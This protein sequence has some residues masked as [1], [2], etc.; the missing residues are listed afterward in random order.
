M[1]VTGCH[2]PPFFFQETKI[3]LSIE[4]AFDF[5]N[6]VVLITGAATGIGFSTAQQFAERGAT[7]V[8]VDRDEKIH[9]VT[10]ALGTRHLSLVADVSNEET[11]VSSVT[12][13][14]EK[15]GRIDVLVNNAGIGPLS[16]SEETTSALWDATMAVNLKGSFL[17]AREVGKH[18]ILRKRGRIINMASQAALVA[19]DGHLAYCASKAG[20]L[21]MTRVMAQEWGPL[22]ITVNAISPTVVDTE[23]GARGSWAGEIGAAFKKKIP[24]GRFALPVEIAMS[25]LYLASGAAAMVNGANIVVDGGYTAG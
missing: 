13:A 21:G 8:L 14:I 25:A 20:V 1:V 9:E 6:Q 23:L 3:Q 10:Q 18:M 19:L 7:L 15:F 2:S 24:T 4:Q 11:V 16:K 22:G 17:F 5:S 12:I